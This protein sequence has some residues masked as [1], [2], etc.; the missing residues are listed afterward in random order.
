MS[1]AGIA[2]GLT[3]VSYSNAIKLARERNRFYLFSNYYRTG[4]MLEFYIL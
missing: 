2:T 3:D 1:E 4:T